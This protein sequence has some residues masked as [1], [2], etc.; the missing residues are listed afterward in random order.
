MKIIR[1]A[2]TPNPIEDDA[3]YRASNKYDSGNECVASLT[4]DTS[5]KINLQ[6]VLRSDKNK[7][8]ENKDMTSAVDMLHPF[9][10]MRRIFCGFDRL[11][12]NQNIKIKIYGLSPC[13]HLSLFQ[14]LQVRLIFSSYFVLV[15][16]HPSSFVRKM[17]S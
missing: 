11:D 3:P 7:N 10:G 12:R 1:S 4:R 13:E 9:M 5:H 6:K 15:T 2:D 17:F 14:S 8:A 16:N